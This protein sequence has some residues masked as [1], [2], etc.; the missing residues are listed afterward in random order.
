[1]NLGDTLEGAMKQSWVGEADDM[2]YIHVNCE[3]RATC[4]KKV[5]DGTCTKCGKRAAGGI[6][7]YRFRFAGRIIH[8]SSH[9]RSRTVALQ[10]ERK[11][12]RQLEEAW[13]GIKKRAM[14]PSFEQTQNR[15][16]EKHNAIAPSTRETYT[17]AL[18]H[19]ATF[20]GSQLVCDINA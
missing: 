7:W 14:P 10:S 1:M 20:F 12:R 15:W 18:T 17:H 3:V 13:N 6:W 8:E 11:S 16:L 2:V 4:N 9:S 19:L 5:P